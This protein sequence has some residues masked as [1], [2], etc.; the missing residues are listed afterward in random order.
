MY[1]NFIFGRRGKTEGEKRTAEL[2]VYLQRGEKR[3]KMYHETGFISLNISIL[4][5]N[6]IL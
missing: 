1:L 3:F 5:S 6:A 2:V 4:R